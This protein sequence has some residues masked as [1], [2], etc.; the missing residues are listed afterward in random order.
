MSRNNMFNRSLNDFTEVT[1]QTHSRIGTRIKAANL[2]CN[3]FILGPSAIHFNTPVRCYAAQKRGLRDWVNYLFTSISLLRHIH[4]ECTL[5]ITGHLISV[6]LT[7]RC[8]M[9]A[10]Q[11]HGSKSQWASFYKACCFVKMQNHRAGNSIICPF[12]APLPTCLFV[13]L[14]LVKIIS[15]CHKEC[16]VQAATRITIFYLLL[17]SH[18]PRRS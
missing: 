6:F 15:L 3:I 2:F 14:Y 11:Y 16:N 9:H 12:P 1:H 7:D 10:Q 17:L 4:S 5:L 13:C 18:S 8:Q